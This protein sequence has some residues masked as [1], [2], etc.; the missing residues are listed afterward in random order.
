LPESLSRW[1]ERKALARQGRERKEATVKTKFLFGMVF[2]GIIVLAIG[3]FTVRRS[4]RAVRVVFRPALPS[5]KRTGV[6][7]ARPALA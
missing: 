2:A 3:G 7:A 5:A 1:E 6:T 4:R